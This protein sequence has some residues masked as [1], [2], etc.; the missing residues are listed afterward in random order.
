MATRNKR[1]LA[2]LNNENREE[3]PRSSL[4]QNSK[5]QRSQ[6]DYITQILEQI[7]G[8]VTEKMS[9]EFSRTENRMLGALARLYDFPMNPLIQ[10]HSGTAP[11]TSRNALSTSQGP[12]EDHHPEEGIFNNQ[13]T[14]NSGA[15]IG[16]DM[17]TGNTEQ[18]GNRHGMVTEVHE[19]VTY[20]S[21]ITSS[22]KQKNNRST[23]QPQFRSEN[24][25][26]TFEADQ[27]VL[28]LQ[29]LANNHNSAK[30]HNNINRISKLT[31]SLTTTIPT[32]DGKSEKIELFEY[33]FQ[34][35]PKFRNQ[36]TEDNRI[37]YFHYLM[38]GDALQT[39]KNFNGHTQK[40]LGEI[41]AVV[42]RKYLK[43]QSMSRAKNKFQKLA[44]NPANQ[45][46]V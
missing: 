5:V 26:A 6:E 20:C 16:Q 32:F 24:T 8:R 23:S 31:K 36:L 34:T 11:E 30:F 19:E 10:G 43:P 25:P 9:Q 40:N 1:K 14:Q 7:G 13:M 15:E 3:H 39:F 41:L 45:N 33:L 18:I 17:V 35:S 29:Q 28:A 2:A 44:F 27:I 4:A 37:N 21:P 12:D 46:F 38:K 42:Q 22:G